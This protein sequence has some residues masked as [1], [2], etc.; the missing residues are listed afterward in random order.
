[1]THGDPDEDLEQLRRDAARA[2]RRD[3]QDRLERELAEAQR[4]LNASLRADRIR[5]AKKIIPA[6]LVIGGLLLWWDHRGPGD[7][8]G[9]API[10]QREQLMVEHQC[11]PI[12][13]G[14]GG[15]AGVLIEKA[16]ED[17]KVAFMTFAQDIQRYTGELA[18]ETGPY[19]LYADCAR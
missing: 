7:P 13:Q 17:G 6:A 1:M 10:S 16:G 3:E 15:G 18:I 4:R 19:F 9:A 5:A 8:P 11:T 12:T 14:G 2:R